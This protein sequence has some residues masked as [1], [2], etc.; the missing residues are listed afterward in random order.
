MFTYDTLVIYY[1]N[2]DP[3]TV[4]WH[5]NQVNKSALSY[6]HTQCP[7]LRLLHQSCHPPWRML[8]VSTFMLPTFLYPAR[9]ALSFSN[10][11]K[12]TI[13][14]FSGKNFTLIVQLLKTE[15]SPLFSINNRHQYQPFSTWLTCKSK[16]KARVIW[17]KHCAIFRTHIVWQPSK[18]QGKSWNTSLLDASTHPHAPTVM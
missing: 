8:N 12:R 9:K 7:L 2:F 3:A 18:K 16:F 6:E 15:A 4:H 10:S 14:C 17:K 11:K 1:I 13:K 5:I